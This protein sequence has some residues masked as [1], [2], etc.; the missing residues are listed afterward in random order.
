MI[1]PAPAPA[2]LPPPSPWPALVDDFLASLT[3]RQ[4]AP[5]TTDS[6]R[7]HLRRLLPALAGLL[8]AD[9]GPEAL[10]LALGQV[11]SGWPRAYRTANSRA[12]LTNACRS[13]FR[14]AAEAGSL[15]KNPAARIVLRHGEGAGAVPISPGDI[16]RLLS[17]IHAADDR[18]R[19]R[20]EALFAVYAFTGVRRGEALALW[21]GDYQPESNSLL[22]RGKGGGRRRLPVIAPLRQI[23]DTHLATL[24]QP[25]H[26]RPLFAGREATRPLSGRQADKRFHRWRQLAGLPPGLTIHSFRA[27]LAST[28]YQDSHDLLLV[29][30]LL[31]H[32]DLRST[33]RYIT[34]PTDARQA[35]E[36]AF[37]P[38]TS[39]RGPP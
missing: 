12:L 36:Q 17:T 32:R 24:P 30:R 15:A 39:R 10:R 23:L 28:L 1:T 14:W 34:M 7:L 11:R 25:A 5:A 9:C 29:S 33:C 31:G 37:G 2:L 19:L 21:T 20:D 27:G 26:D 13:F 16:Q 3:A 18:H 35:L 38:S 8:P 22:V 6:Y 4:Y